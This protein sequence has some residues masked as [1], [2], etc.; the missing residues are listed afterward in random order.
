[1]TETVAESTIRGYLD[2][3]GASA[4]VAEIA[5]NTGYSPSAVYIAL[6][7]IRARRVK[8]GKNSFGYVTPS[9]EDLPIAPEALGT[10]D[11]KPW[12]HV[13]KMTLRV[14]NEAHITDSITPKEYAEGFEALGHRLLELAAHAAAVQDRPDWQIVLGFK[15]DTEQ[16]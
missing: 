11:G 8:K 10:L 3:I 5:E 2:S 14:V 6:K 12:A 1:M 16:E 7:A 15:Q 13:A 4:T 9:P